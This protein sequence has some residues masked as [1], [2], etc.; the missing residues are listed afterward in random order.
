MEID[1]DHAEDGSQLD[2]HHE[3]VDEG[4]WLTKLDYVVGQ[5]QVA[6]GG[7]WQEFRD[8]FNDAE[9]NCFKDI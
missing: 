2:D 6:R 3:H 1:H 9:D 4:L 7:D 5:V 8:P